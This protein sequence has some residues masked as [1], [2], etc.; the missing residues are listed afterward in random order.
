LR[1]LVRTED[2]PLLPAVLDLLGGES[3]VLEIPTVLA[4][5]ERLGESGCRL[6]DA[7]VEA[8]QTFRRE[9]RASS[10]LEGEVFLI[11]TLLP[12]T[13]VVGNSGQRPQHCFPDR[14]GAPLDDPTVQLEPVRLR[15]VEDHEALDPAHPEVGRLLET[16]ILD[17]AVLQNLED[18]VLLHRALADD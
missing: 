1:E 7:S 14:T 12:N 17:R 2:Q 4:R 6:V 15:R 9:I 10:S 5:Q 8:L 16:E 18:Q 11:A 3:V 13:I